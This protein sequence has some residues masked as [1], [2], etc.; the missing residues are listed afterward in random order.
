MLV[1]NKNPQVYKERVISFIYFAFEEVIT[2]IDWLKNMKLYVF[3][4]E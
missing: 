3:D 4:I 1:K 2:V